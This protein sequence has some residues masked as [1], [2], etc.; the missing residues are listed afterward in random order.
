[1]LAGE[2]EETMHHLDIW[3]VSGVA[4]GNSKQM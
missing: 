2:T 1:M 4:H 3:D